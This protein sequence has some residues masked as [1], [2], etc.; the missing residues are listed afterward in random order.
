MAY[1]EEFT[2]SGIIER[3]IIEDGK[4]I[5]NLEGN[6][7]MAFTVDGELYFLDKIRVRITYEDKR[8]PSGN[9]PVKVLELFKG[10]KTKEI[11]RND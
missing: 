2:N 9:Y 11:Y 8:L 4:T 7:V 5:I 3:Y 10:R 6:S 1:G